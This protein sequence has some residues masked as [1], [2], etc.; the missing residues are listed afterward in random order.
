MKKNQVSGI[1]IYNDF[2]GYMAFHHS[3][4]SY[5]MKLNFDK[6]KSL[7]LVEAFL[8]CLTKCLLD[9][10]LVHKQECRTACASVPCRQFVALDDDFD[11]AGFYRVEGDFLRIKTVFV[12]LA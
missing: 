9:I 1:N 12:F 6:K 10:D 3:G 8:F 11:I 7:Q 4:W 5:K 2:S